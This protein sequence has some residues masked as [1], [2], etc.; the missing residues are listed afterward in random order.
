MLT[1]TYVQAL[2]DFRLRLVLSNQKV[3]TPCV[4]E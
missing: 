1:I 2:P 3:I 4:E